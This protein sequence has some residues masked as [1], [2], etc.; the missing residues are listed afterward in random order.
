M[1][2]RCAGVHEHD[3]CHGASAALSSRYPETLARLIVMMLRRGFLRRSTCA[4][5]EVTLRV[6]SSQPVPTSHQVS[7]DTRSPTPGE[8][9]SDAK[10]SD[11]PLEDLVR[12][13]ICASRDTFPAFTLACAI[14]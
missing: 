1:G 13:P 11:A 10:T 8:D 12:T 14:F 2:L 6:S 9:R 5:A 3:S 7:V 4:L